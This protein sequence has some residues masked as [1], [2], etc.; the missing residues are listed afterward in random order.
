MRKHKNY[1]SGFIHVATAIII[2]V[3]LL[4]GAG[5]FGARNFPRVYK[6]PP[7][8][9]QE[10]VR[11]GPISPAATIDSGDWKTYRNEKYGFEM[12]YPSNVFALVQVMNPIPDRLKSDPEMY[13]LVSA[14]R[15][16]LLGKTECYY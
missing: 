2:G 15:V 3:L 14:K 1:Q 5:Y 16:G 13:K 9:P 10:V 6:E 4:G 11:P 12:G 8:V 7:P